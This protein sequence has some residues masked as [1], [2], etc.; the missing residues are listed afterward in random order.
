MKTYNGFADRKAREKYVCRSEITRN[1]LTKMN[2]SEKVS[3]AEAKQAF[4]EIKN[5]FVVVSTGSS[6]DRMKRRHTKF[7]SKYVL[8]DQIIKGLRRH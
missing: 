3:I 4:D 6:S 5:D 2:I 8:Y 7:V 1:L